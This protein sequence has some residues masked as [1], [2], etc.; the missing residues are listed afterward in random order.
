[1]K[2]SKERK[3]KKIPEDMHIDCQP[4]REISKQNRKRSDETKQQREAKVPFLEGT[5]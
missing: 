1:M 5:L 2:N 3:K 4:R